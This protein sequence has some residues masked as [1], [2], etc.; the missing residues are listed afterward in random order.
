MKR[1]FDTNLK[2]HSETWEVDPQRIHISFKGE[3]I[4]S[5]SFIGKLVE[6]LGPVQL[7][8]L[9]KTPAVIY[10]DDI[11]DVDPDCILNPGFIAGFVKDAIEDASPLWDVILTKSIERDV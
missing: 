5:R 1:Y 10:V 2:S 9:F 4:G 11:L 7:G 6:D 8:E 3:R